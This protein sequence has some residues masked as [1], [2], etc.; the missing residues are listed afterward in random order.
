MESGGIHCEGGAGCLMFYTRSDQSQC[1]LELATKVR[2][3]FTITLLGGDLTLK[4]LLRHYAKWPLKHS[5]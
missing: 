1:S 3:D 2:R 4:K 5:K